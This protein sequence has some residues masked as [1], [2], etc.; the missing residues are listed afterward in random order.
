M[1]ESP[2]LNFAGRLISRLGANSALIDASSGQVLGAAEIQR[3]VASF[4]AGFLK[5]GLRPGDRLL[6]GCGLNPAGTLAYLGAMYAGIIPVLVDDRT[7]STSAEGVFK[8]ANAKAVWTGRSGGWDWSRKNAVPLIEGH[9]DASSAVPFPPSPC[10]EDDLAVLMPTSGS[11][12]H[13]RLVKVSHGNLMANTDAIIRTQHLAS[14]DKAMLIMPVSYCFGASIMH[15]HLYQGGAVVF[16]SSFIFPDKVLNAI[17]L[18]GCTTF[19]GVPTVYNILLRR[20][21]LRSIALPRL[22]RFLQAGG[23]LAVESVSELREIVPHADFFVMYGQTEA[24]ARISSLPANSYAEKL[25]SVGRVLDNLAI[26]I[27]DDQG[28]ELPVGNTGEIQVSGPSVCAGYFNDPDATQGKFDDGW[29]RTGDLGR[30]DEDGYIWLMGRTS[31]FIK[32]RGIRLSL[33]EVES[34][35]VGVPGVCE[36]AAAAVEHPEA[37]EALALY[38]VRDGSEENGTPSL[39]DRVRQALPP[40]WTCASVKLVPELPKTPNGKIARSLLHTVA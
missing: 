1:P 28:Q 40:Q 31:E 37:G 22:R 19:A 39:I 12:G 13:P 15:T 17:N 3:S 10:T 33:A 29:L 4:A 8:K 11:T 26:R 27:V 21:N 14:D 7:L 2:E 36:C 32:I 35:V 34:K 20:S 16:D 6:I 18:Y 38:V 25:G 23:A 9:L 5:T 24:T 30:L